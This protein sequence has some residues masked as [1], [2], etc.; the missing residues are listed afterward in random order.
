MNEISQSPK[1]ATASFMSAMHTELPKPAPAEGSPPVAEV[2]KTDAPTPDPKIAATTTT[3]PV[4]EKIPRTS[5]EWKKFTAKRDADIAERDARI[6]TAEKKASELEAKS[7]TAT[8]SPELDALKADLEK[9]RKERDE[10]DERLKMVA[11]TQHPTFK[12]EFETR[13]NSQIELA[14]KIVPDEQ[15]E[16]VERILSMPEGNFRDARIEELMGEL[17]QVQ[18]ARIGSILNSVTEINTA[19]QD[20]IAHSKEEYDKMTAAQQAQSDSRTAQMEAALKNSLAKAP[21]HPL[22]KKSEDTEWNKDVDARIKQVETIAR[23]SLSVADSTKI[24]LDHLALP[25]IQKQLDAS[26]AE[27]EKLKAQIADFTAA[28]PGIISRSKE[29]GLDEGGG[30]PIKINPGSSPMEAARSWMKSLPKFG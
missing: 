19:R 9:I 13:L 25:V 29:T 18:A 17:S 5:Q 14:K 15:K 27:V 23:S 20:I 1:D 8:P 28:N 21:E 6:A 2:K 12:R 30:T 7:K 24:V 3:V 26:K 11:V 4:E 22:Y 10:Y 16:A